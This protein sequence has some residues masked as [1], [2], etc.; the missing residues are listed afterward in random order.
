MLRVLLGVAGG[1]LA[2]V[3]LVMVLS[4]LLYAVLGPGKAFEPGSSEMTPLWL[5]LSLAVSALAAA[6]GGRVASGIAQR[7][8]A[9][10]ALAGAVVLLGLY[11][12]WSNTGAPTPEAVN[13]EDLAKF[14]VMRNARRPDW[15]TWIIPLVEAAFVLFAGILSRR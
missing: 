6:V 12:A 5:G 3:I 11:A 4:T 1:Y 9:V 8:E 7:N 15:Y 2:M 10:I 14:E 13:L